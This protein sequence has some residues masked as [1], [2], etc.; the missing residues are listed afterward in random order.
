[1]ENTIDHKKVDQF[2][3]SGLFF[4]FEPNEQGYKYF[5]PVN[6]G[7]FTSKDNKYWIFVKKIY[8]KQPTIPRNS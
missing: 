5:V 6:G 4:E 7:Y 8:G 3:K 1:M 2:K